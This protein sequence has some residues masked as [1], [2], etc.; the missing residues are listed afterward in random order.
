MGLV[1]AAMIVIY[2]VLKFDQVGYFRELLYSI[3]GFL[4]NFSAMMAMTL[5]PF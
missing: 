1:N 5:V 2:T 4:V 3:L